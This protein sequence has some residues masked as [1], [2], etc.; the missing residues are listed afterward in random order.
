MIGLKSLAKIFRLQ[1]PV[2]SQEEKMGEDKPGGNGWLN[3]G[4]IVILCWMIKTS[5]ETAN[6]NFDNERI[7]NEICWISYVF[8]MSASVMVVGSLLVLSNRLVIVQ[9]AFY[10]G[11]QAINC[12]IAKTFIL[13]VPL[14]PWAALISTCLFL[15]YVFKLHSVF[16]QRDELENPSTKCIIAF[17]LAPSLIY[18]EYPFKISIP[19]LRSLKHLAF[20]AFSLAF[21]LTIWMCHIDPL[22]KEAKGLELVSREMAFMHIKLIPPWFVF[23]GTMSFAVFYGFL[24]LM[25]DLISY[26]HRDFYE[27]W[28]NTSNFAM[29][30][31]KWKYLHF[32]SV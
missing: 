2:V 27:D 8:C 26:P 29:F 16:D 18:F 20:I 23:W 25:G 10:L 19:I 15:I 24:N 6:L 1:T 22:L 30:W 4:V 28:W 21:S 14:S 9:F 13:D 17:V 7:L 31:K 11:F 12:W 32:H 3:V 5:S